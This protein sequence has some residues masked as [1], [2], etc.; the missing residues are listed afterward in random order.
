MKSY[1]KNAFLYA[2]IVA[3]GGFVFGLDAALISGT[4][5]SIEAEFSLDSIHLG[6]VVS[7]PALGVLFALPFAGYM[8][9]RLGR[10][11]TLLLVA[12]LYLVSALSYAFAPTAT[13]LWWA[14]FLGGLAFSSISLAS[15]YIGEIAPPK[16][17]G[18]LVS[19]TQINIVIGLSGAYFVNYLIHHWAGPDAAWVTSLGID[20][21]TWRWMLGSEIPFALLWFG[22]LMFIPESPYWLVYRDRPQEAHGVLQALLP[23]EE[24]APHIAEMKASLLKSSQSHS[25]GAQIAELFGRPMR[26]TFIIALTLAIAQQSTGI[27][28]IL[29]YAQTVFQQLGIGTDAAF[30]QAVWVGVVSVV[31]TVLGLLL[32]DK[33]GRRP[34]IIGGMVWIVASLGVCA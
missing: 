7:A 15:M 22:L 17:R 29:F 19:M 6:S 27:N 12:L 1:T 10:K 5:D 18:K 3:M 16:W 34:L 31:S 11:R 30:A 25:V 2:T 23:K 13:T 26:L 4:V 8:C 14:R 33:L 28:A 9:N 20:Q 32:V 24:I 21:N